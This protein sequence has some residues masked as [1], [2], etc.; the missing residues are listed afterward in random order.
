MLEDK[1]Q[2]EFSDKILLLAIN[3]VAKLKSKH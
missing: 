1:Y 3:R 2:K